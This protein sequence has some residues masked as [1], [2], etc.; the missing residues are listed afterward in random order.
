MAGRPTDSI[1]GYF[2]KI[3]DADTGKV[4]AALCV[5]CKTKVSAKADR[6]RNH[7][8]KCAK[9][10]DKVVGAGASCNL[11]STS[12]KDTDNDKRDDDIA[13]VLEVPSSKKR[14]QDIETKMDSYV[15]KTSTSQKEICDLQVAR[16]FYACNLAFNVVEHPEFRKMLQTLR[17][18]YEPPS[19]K[20][21]GK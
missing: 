3:T 17:P 15:T 20:S 7:R 14:K 18:G 19:R 9:G 21:L 11:P 12:T 8:T 5:T 10:K 13:V 16:A 2:Q 4:T 6:L 1:W